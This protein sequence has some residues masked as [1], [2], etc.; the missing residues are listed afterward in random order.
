MKE[1]IPSP[2]T[3][4]DTYTIYVKGKVK[5]ENTEINGNVYVSLMVLRKCLTVEIPQKSGNLSKVIC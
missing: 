4:E 5:L 1:E 2:S 3:V